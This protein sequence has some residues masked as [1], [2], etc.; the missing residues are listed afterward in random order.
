MF[1]FKRDILSIKAYYFSI[2]NWKTRKFSVLRAGHTST[3]ELA[4]I[5]KWVTVMFDF[6]AEFSALSTG[7]SSSD[8]DHEQKVESTQGRNA[9]PRVSRTKGT[10]QQTD[11][12]FNL[13]KQLQEKQKELQAA[14]EMVQQLRDR[15]KALAER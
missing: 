5:S 7:N 9:S 6:F 4:D 14:K 8:T 3:A 12:K 13:Q 2:L 1:G 10:Q 15:E 11:E